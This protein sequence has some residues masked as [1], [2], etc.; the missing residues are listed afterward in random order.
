MAPKPRIIGRRPVMDAATRRQRQVD[1][2]SNPEH[3]WR[4][5]YIFG[6]EDILERLHGYR[7]GA[8][9]PIHLGDELRNGRYRVIHK[10]GSGGF[11]TVWLCQ[12]LY[13]DEPTYV[14]VKILCASQ[15]ADT[16]PEVRV[17]ELLKEMSSVLV[18]L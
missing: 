4:R 15:K 18:V 12:D 9:C 17:A 5:L 16:N 7:P 8:Y 2:L 6:D 14:A 1:F 10:L 11:G 13:A 3:M